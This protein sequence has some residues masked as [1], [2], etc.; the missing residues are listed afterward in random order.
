MSN[1]QSGQHDPR[2]FDPLILVGEP[3]D[4]N[5]DDDDDDEED[6]VHAGGRHA[7][8]CLPYD[9]LDS[10]AGERRSI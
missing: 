3:R 7:L 2:F 9:V 4:P 5:D 10:D 1:V 8:S 6:D